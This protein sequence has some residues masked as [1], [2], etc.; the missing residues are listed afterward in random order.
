MN[1]YNGWTN[2]ETWLANIWLD[3]GEVEGG[4]FIKLATELSVI[5]LADALDEYYSSVLPDLPSGLYADLLAGAV[6][7]INWREIAKRF[8][9]DVRS[10]W[11]PEMAREFGDF[12]SN[13][14][15]AEAYPRK[16]FWMGGSK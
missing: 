10:D 1:S 11:S 16:T 13:E 14:E 2:R 6:A 15:V 12:R 3:A 9:D 4:A 7:R 8:S 5:E